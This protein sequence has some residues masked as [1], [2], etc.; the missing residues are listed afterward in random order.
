MYSRRPQS[1]KLALAKT[2]RI[3][4]SVL[5]G[6]SLSRLALSTTSSPLALPP[7]SPLCNAL[8]HLRAGLEA[9]YTFFGATSNRFNPRRPRPLLTRVQSL[10]KNTQPRKSKKR[11]PLTP[12]RL[13][14][15]KLSLFCAMPTAVVSPVADIYALQSPV[16]SARRGKILDGVGASKASRKMSF[17]CVKP[18]AVVSPSLSDG[19]SE[20]PPW[21]AR[22]TVTAE[23]TE[24]VE[25]LWSAFE[26]DYANPM[27]PD[28]ARK[29]SFAISGEPVKPPQKL[30]VWSAIDT[31]D[32]TYSESEYETCGKNDFGSVLHAVT[33]ISRKLTSK[34][35]DVPEVNKIMLFE[36]DFISFACHREA[37]R[38]FGKRNGGVKGFLAKV[39]S[40]F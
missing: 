34:D 40:K 5:D 14:G 15:R 13:Q 19:N 3:H 7:T 35:E 17:A 11:G 33:K 32:D 20:L 38:G 30:P 26:N 24:D 31:D 2:P 16:W 29:V 4:L 22:R 8:D 27:K 25:C 18:S 37:K 9:N 10:F 36:D 39:V 28:V 1:P 12:M 21:M 23:D 6:G